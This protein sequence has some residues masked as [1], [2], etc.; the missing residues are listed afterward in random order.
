MKRQNCNALC[1]LVLAI[2]LAGCQAQVAFDPPQDHRQIDS[3]EFLHLLA[4]Q[5]M[6]NF[7]QACRAVVILA[8]GEDRVETFDERFAALESRGIVRSQWGLQPNHAVDRGTLAYMILRA[9]QVQDSFNNWLSSFSGLGDRRYA[10]R[11]LIDV[12]IMAYGVPYQIPSG[13][14]VAQALAQADDHMAKTGVYQATDFEIS[15]P[16]DLQGQQGG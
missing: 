10:L 4:Q 12:K 13:G 1:A 2:G 9:A 11:R 15:S 7:D 8:D 6:V 14:E 16:T 5:P 3:L